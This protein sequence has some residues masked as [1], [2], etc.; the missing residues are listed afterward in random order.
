[1]RAYEIQEET[2]DYEGV[3]QTERPRPDVGHG[4]ALVRVHACSINYRDL[5]VAD[6]T[7]A[8]P[9]FGLPLVPLCD[10]AGEVVE[11][12]EGV[13]RVEV[14]D[15]VVTPFAPN[16]IEGPPAP[17][18]LGISTGGSIDGTL[19][20]FTALPARSLTPLPDYLSYE[21]GCTLTCAGL[22]AWRAL[23]E[24]G[25]LG[26]GETVLCL[27]TGGVSIF[28][29]QL[30]RMHGSRAIVTSSSDEKLERARE[31]GA[32]ETLNY[33]DTPEWGEAVQEMTDG[34][35]VDH[36]V[37]VGGV[38]TLER[39]L[40]AAA[41]GGHVHLIG[42]L[43]GHEGEIDPGPILRKAIQVEG[44]INVGSRAML[45]RM[46]RAMA[47]EE[48]HPVVDRTFDFEEAREAYR[49]V[50]DGAHFGKVVIRVD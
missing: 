13:E 23:A 2:P 33:E 35:G 6:G 29:L 27:G 31:L 48:M 26:A 8:Y 36:V 34:E 11:V 45:D 41:L 50:D 12:G 10:G 20:E 19:A 43:T 30:A 47:V 17:E 7:L 15:R 5:A 4:E 37:E 44:V 14:G 9:G 42:V 32:W 24:D 1:M 38:G 25:D 3:V 18:K 39:S 16:W 22:T 40:E 28:A 21:E 49:Y 46:T